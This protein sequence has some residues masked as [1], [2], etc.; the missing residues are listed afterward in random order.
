MPNLLP[1]ERL[2]STV[3][4]GTL[5]AAATS[6]VPTK[7][8]PN[9]FAKLCLC[10]ILL[11][12]DR[13]ATPPLHGH[14][15]DTESLR[16]WGYTSW[17]KRFLTFSDRLSSSKGLK[18][19]RGY[20]RNLARATCDRGAFSLFFLQGSSIWE[21]KTCPSQKTDLGSKKQTNCSIPDEK[22]H[23]PGI[24]RESGGGECRISNDFGLSPVIQKPFEI[25]KKRYTLIPLSYHASLFISFF[26]KLY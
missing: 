3:T 16:G 2:N 11:K 24:Q 19:S 1:S 15:G 17:A 26:S 25:A 14:Q 10:V 4:E 22:P 12:K 8:Y 7:N 13:S 18:Q 20:Y 23:G 5:T 21:L 6:W 9:I